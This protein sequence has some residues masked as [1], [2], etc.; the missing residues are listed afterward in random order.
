MGKL[1]ASMQTKVAGGQK[2]SKYLGFELAGEEYGLEILKVRE[3][4]GMM[5]ITP[6]PQLP[7]H[8]KGVINLRGKVIPVIDLRLKF[9]LDPIDYHERTCI[10]VVEIKGTSGPLPMGIVVDTVSEV[11]SVEPSE[12][13]AAPNLGLDHDIEYVLGLAKLRGGVKI[14]LDIDRVLN[15]QELGLGDQL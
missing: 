15:V 10:I 11:M 8:V 7:P 6:L 9:G 12:I 2:D 13:E 1:T 5:D 4:I 3:I 14:L